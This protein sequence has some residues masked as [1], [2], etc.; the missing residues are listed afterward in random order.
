MNV[1]RKIRN[2]RKSTISD[3][4]EKVKYNFDLNVLNLMC[5][6]ILSSN[7]NIRKSHIINMKNLFE[8][9]DISI[10]ERDPEKMKRVRFIQRGL[11][12]RLVKDL[13]NTTS[14]LTY[15]NGGIIDGGMEID[16][17]DELSNSELDF[18]NETVSGALKCTF[19]DAE[20][21]SFFELYT[22][23]KAQDYRYRDEM[24]AEIEGFTK[25]LN[26]KFR[27]ARVEDNINT[28]FSLDEGVF[29]N[30]V[31]DI[32]DTITASN[33]F[34]STGMQGFNMLVGGGLEA[35]R[36]YLIVGMAGIG[37]SML[38]LNLALQIKKYNMGYQT[39][40]PTKIPTI[41]FLTQENSI[42]ETVDRI[43]DM[44]SGKNMKEFSKEE[45]IN[46]LKNDG[47]LNLMGENNINIHII[48]RADRSIDTGDLYGIAEDLEDDGYEVIALLQDHIKRIRSIFNFNG[49][50]RLELGAVMNEF[51]TFA[52]LKQIPVIT[53]SHLNRDA[54]VKLENATKGNKTDLTRLLGRSNVGES[55]LMIDNTD[56]S[57]LANKD[58]DEDGN[59]YICLALDKI[60]N[61]TPL[62][63]YICQPFESGSNTKLVEDL[64]SNIPAFRDTLIPQNQING[65]VPINI[66]GA[67]IK[68]SSYTNISALEQS[69]TE[70]NIF[71][72]LLS[73]GTRYSSTLNETI[74]NVPIDGEENVIFYDDVSPLKVNVVSYNEDDIEPAKTQQLVSFY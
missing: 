7:S 58:Y 28:V 8:K 23:Y 68:P 13:K 2:S 27:S 31:S 47:G 5:S 43:C 10:Y 12:A 70:Q 37:K 62:R 6:Y 14:I 74:E 50:M 63:D 69:D 67:L 30:K 44:I 11:E 15:I 54:S 33:R 17:F 55:L 42:E 65:N 46:I 24:V 51:C 66:N 4:N 53:V 3:S 49:D 52:K 41:L 22:K 29:E 57:I 40:D 73:G 45:V 48:W 56:C 61:A 36:T 26:N 19:I 1:N 39:K 21:D 25:N 20:M 38:L 18:I 16:S 34:L 32:Y 72:P 9:I 35:T 64:Y 71:E 59:P 60:R